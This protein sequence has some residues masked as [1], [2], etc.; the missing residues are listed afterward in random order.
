MPS[1]AKRACPG[2]GG[3]VSG[4]RCT[5]CRSQKRQ[6]KDVDRLSADDRGYSWKW[7][8]Y[9]T[10]WRDRHPFCGE[11]ADGKLSAEHSLCAAEDRAVP[12]AVTDHIV[13]VRGAD[14]PLFWD[15][16]N[17]Q[18][19]CAACHNRKT[20]TEDGGFLRK[21]AGERVVVTGPPGSGKTTWVQQR[22][23]PGDVVFD[24]DAIAQVVT[25]LPTYPRPLDATRALL[26]MRDG[27]V[28]WL[29]DSHVNV[30]VFVIVT[31]SKEA[32][33]LARRI[34]ARI[35]KRGGVRHL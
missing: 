8:N 7:R 27:L 1:A 33:H 4:G 32:E 30:H 6:G 23:R 19:L 2:C 11:R 18:S 29:N 12:P 13:P 16:A 3:I 17:H 9:S 25:Q 31:D 34:N 20:A 5:K 26:A 28:G 21:I 22:A 24:L 14:D 15:P 35:I 10:A